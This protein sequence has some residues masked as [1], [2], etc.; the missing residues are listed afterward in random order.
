[1]AYV[2]LIHDDRGQNSFAFFQRFVKVLRISSARGNKGL[3]PGM[4]NVL[5]LGLDVV[6]WMHIYIKAHQAIY[7]ICVLHCI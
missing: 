5:C 6:T 4:M 2:K 7:L 3:F 1:M